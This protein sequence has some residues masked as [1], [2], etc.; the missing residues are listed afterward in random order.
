[1]TSITIERDLAVPLEL[2]DSPIHF[3]IADRKERW[4]MKLRFGLVTI[5]IFACLA[6]AVADQA[7]GMPPLIDRDLI[8][9]NPEIAAAQ[10]SPD[11]KYI[12]FLKPWK[13]TRNIY[14]K[15]V[16]EPFSAARLLTTEAKRPVAGYFW[17]RDS[18]YILYV[19]DNDGDENYNIYAVDPS[20]KPAAGADAPPSRDLTGL[21]GVRVEIFEVPKSD[22]DVVYIGLNDRDKAWHD[23]YR[24]KLSTGTKELVRKN[25]ERITGWVFDLKGQLR[26]ATRSAENGDTEML[27]VDADGF[28]KVYSCTVFETCDPLQFQPGNQRIYM[29]TNKGTDLVSLVLFDPQTMQTDMVESDPLGKVDFGGALFSEATDELVETW[30]VTDRVKEYYKDKAFGN[31]VHFIEGTFPGDEIKVFS[32][33]KDDQVWLVTAVSDTEPGET[34]LFDRKTRVLTPQ[35]KIREKLPR[36]D[37]APMKSVTYKSSDGLEIPAYLTLPKGV[38]GKNLPTLII[39]H[40]GPWGRDEWGYNPIAQFFA[41]RGYAVLMPN[42]RGSTGYGRKFLDAGNLQWGRK[43]QDDLTWGVKYR[44]AE[45]I[46]DPKR[47]AILGGS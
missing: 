42:F 39:P 20:A 6:T 5:L 4:H 17:T 46:A 34:L 44:V 33:T 43:M 3:P 7:S 22:P 19:K 15:A 12:A 23:L 11:G 8:F 40:G 26:M 9:G 14:V 1:M 30:Y 29:Q 16:G 18:K 13:D 31:D 32:R 28:S 2:L 38:P 37:L 25:T 35:F 21:K 36:A 45:G 47:V 24:L 27:R 10:I 41:N